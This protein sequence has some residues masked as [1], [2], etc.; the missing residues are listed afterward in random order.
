MPGVTLPVATCGIW[1]IAVYNMWEAYGDLAAV[2]TTLVGAGALGAAAFH[3][4]VAR[5]IKRVRMCLRPSFGFK[6]GRLL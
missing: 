2:L 1:C 3:K 6:Q 5:F 4:P